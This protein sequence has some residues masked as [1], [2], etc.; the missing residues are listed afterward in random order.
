[1]HKS[2]KG[3]SFKSLEVFFLSPKLRSI[4]ENI[5]TMEKTLGRE[6]AIQLKPLLFDFDA[7][8]YASEV[9]TFRRHAFVLHNGAP[10]LLFPL[11]EDSALIAV[12][13]SQLHEPS[14][15]WS[16]VYRLKIVSIGIYDE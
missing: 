12:N 2:L 15:N 7:A 10:A 16:N 14:T 4:C 11:H 13:N 5:K 6:C 3:L 1:M 8:D 9:L